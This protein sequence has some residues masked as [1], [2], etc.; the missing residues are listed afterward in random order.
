MNMDPQAIRELVKEKYGEAAA[1]AKTGGSSC[2]GASPAL[3]NV[4]PIT[5]NLYSDQERQG[6]RR[7]PSQPRWAAG[8]P[9]HWLNF[10]LVR[11]CWIWDRAAAS[12]SCS[13][14]SESGRQG[15]RMGST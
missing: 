5:S 1:R 14:P 7:M 4:D 11:P 12:M 6:S 8:I 15:K 9:R 13:L 3:M 10:R 2:C